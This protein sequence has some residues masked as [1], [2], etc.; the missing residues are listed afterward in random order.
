MRPPQD[1]AL[2]FQNRLHDTA[3]TLF[4]A[5]AVGL[6]LPEN[7]FDEVLRH[8]LSYRPAFAPRAHPVPAHPDSS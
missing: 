1:V 2:S 7:F 3:I 5:F 8:C 4:R 6:D